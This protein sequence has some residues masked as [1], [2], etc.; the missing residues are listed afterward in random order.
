MSRQRR[1]RRDERR[2][3]E[4]R[5]NIAPAGG[6]IVPAETLAIGVD[7]FPLEFPNGDRWIFNRDKARQIVRLAQRRPHTFDVAQLQELLAGW[8]IKKAD[9]DPADPTVP[10]IAV[11]IDY[12]GQ[13]RLNLIDGAERA[14]KAGIA[15]QSFPIYVLTDQERD[16]CL[17]SKTGMQGVAENSE[18]G[19]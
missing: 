5:R 17:W 2:R 14:V 1:Q 9:V 10:G 11:V 13:R 16:Q 12:A 3:Q 6:T 15:G 18:K 7:I 8:R 19:L 4:A